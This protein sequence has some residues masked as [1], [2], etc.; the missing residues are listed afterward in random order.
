MGS[1]ARLIPFVWHLRQR[2]IASAGLAAVAALL[3]VVSLL[4]VYPVVKLLLEGQGLH[5][6]VAAERQ[7]AQGTIA[8]ETTRQLELAVQMKQLAGEGHA[9]ARLQAQV[10]L[11]TSEDVLT[12]ARWSEWQ[13]EW[14]ASTLLPWVPQDEFALLSAVMGALLAVT[15]VKCCASYWQDVLVGSIVQRTMQSVRK[16]LFRSTLKLDQQTLALETTPQL[17]SRF[18]FDLQQV[19]LGLTLVGSLMVLEPLK[20]LFCVACALR[21][22]WR[23]TALSFVC[24][25]VAVVLFQTFGRGLK[26]ASGRQMES[27]SRVYRVHD[28]TLTS[29]RSVLAFRNE[30]LHRRRLAKEQRDYFEKAQQIVRIDALASP[31]V[32]FLATVAVCATSLPGAYLVLYQQTSIFGITLSSTPMR[33][34]DLALLYTLLAGIL[35][36]ARKLATVYSRVKRAAAACDRVFGWMDRASLLTVSKQSAMLPRHNVAI[37]FDHV[38]FRYATASDAK[39]R[40]T[41]GDSARAPALDDVSVRIPFGATVAVVGG[42]GSGKS[43]LVNLLPR[44]YDAQSGTVRLDGVD[45]C[46]AGLRDLRSQ[47]GVVTQET[48]LFDRTI[49]DNIAYGRAGASR[50]EIEE[51]AKHARVTD[52]ARQLPDGLE[53]HVGDRGHR[54]SG[55]QR[56]RVALARALLRNPAILILDEATSAVDTHSEQLIH[57]T[58]REFS[59]GRTTLIVT[60]AMTTTLVELVSHVLVMDHGRAIAFGRHAEVLA[61]CPVYQRLFDAQSHRRAA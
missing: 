12:A 19:T 28:E 51:A 25:P 33:A 61:T 30:W 17:M 40:T 15:I 24:A 47:I 56:Q 59:V 60:H 26:R 3:S 2:L 11:R 4:L 58:L 6:F 22:N 57:E 7:A 36:P 37:E 23:L 5:E 14:I 32:E 38:T 10:D 29:F 41:G 27:M 46:E 54:L 48:F 34:S 16:R 49:A 52:F 9:A 18:T 21:V 43:T 31:S 55:G 42:N 50:A 13:N 39:G 20:A 1:L 45:L 53:T 35:D 44:F 8:A